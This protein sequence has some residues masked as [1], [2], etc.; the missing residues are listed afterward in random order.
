MN[1]NVRL[2]IVLLVAIGAASVASFAAYRA[3]RNLPVKEVEVGGVPTVVAARPLQVGT[4][5]TRND[6]KVVSWP[7]RALVPGSFRSIDAVVNRGLMAPA[8]ENEPLT[9]AK[10]AAAG[11]GA[12]LPPTIP[13][14]MRAMSLKVND[15]VGV[16]GFVVPGTRVDVVVTIRHAQGGSM[17]RIVLD[18][19]TVLAS[20]TRN[21]QARTG[22]G[23]ASAALLAT[24]VT[25][26]V[27][28]EQAERLTLAGSE[29][30]ITL[31][32]RNPLDAEPVTTTGARVSA[33][34]GGAVPAPVEPAP[35][36]RR[37]VRAAP[38]PPR[39][40]APKPYVVETIRAAKRSEEAIR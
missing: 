1:R 4:L 28:P 11:A 17:S 37:T 23:P 31:V 8:S 25:L 40:E 15:V 34:L 39:P 38:P 2:V 27:T 10:V 35:T 9:D 18:N 3:I 5:L 16:A 22:A 30:S 6:L 12:G 7:E 29:G 21:D 13:A 26:L 14:G 20:G 19:I 33:L 24:V 32:L 36:P